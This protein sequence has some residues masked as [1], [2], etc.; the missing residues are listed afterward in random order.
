MYLDEVIFF[1]DV[2]NESPAI[3]S[4]EKERK[5]RNFL[6]LKKLALI[7][8]ASEDVIDP[9]QSTLVNLIRWSRTVPVLRLYNRL[10]K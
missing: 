4:E 3:S 9:W 8:G 7:G 6:K 5:K 2:N 1:P 10:Q